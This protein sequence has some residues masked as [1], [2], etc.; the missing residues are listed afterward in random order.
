M[1]QQQQHANFDLLAVFSEESKADAAEAKLRKEGF[2]DDEV[3]R[4]APGAV[5]RGEFREHGPNRNRSSVFLQ[6]TRSGPSPVVVTL[7]ALIFAVIFGVI[8]FGVVDFGLK[9][10]PLLPAILIGVLVG[11]IV[12]ALLGLTRR[13]RVRGAIGQDLSKVKPLE[14]PAKKPAETGGQRTVVAVRLPDPENISR[15]SKARAIL[16]NNGGKIDRSVGNS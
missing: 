14:T 12:G 13:G 3:F 11:I 8:S 10:V 15:K 2:G 16:L 1:Q 9:S 6:T 7:F 4:L 5:G